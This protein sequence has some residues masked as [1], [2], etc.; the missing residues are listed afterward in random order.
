[1][2]VGAAKAYAI[3]ASGAHQAAFPA[4]ASN[5]ARAVRNSSSATPTVRTIALC[6]HAGAVET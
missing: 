4:N 3:N 5:V 6:T 1:M 2:H